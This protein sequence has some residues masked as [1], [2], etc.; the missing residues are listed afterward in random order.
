V[1]WLLDRLAAIA[2]QFRDPSVSLFSILAL[3]FTFLSTFLSHRALRKRFASDL[4]AFLL[5]FAFFFLLLFAVPLV[6]LLLAGVGT[7]L[8]PAALGLRIG[9]LKAG[10]L[11]CLVAVPLVIITLSNSARDPV[12]RAWYPFSKDATRSRGRFVLYEAAYILLY[13]FAWDFVFRGLVQFSLVHLLA[14]GLGGTIVAIMAQTLLSTLYHLGHPDGEIWGAFA[15][16]II[17][18]IIAAMTGSF[19]YGFLIHAVIGVANDLYITRYNR[20][21]A[22]RAGPA[23][24]GESPR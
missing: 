11:S 23:G 16:G 18:G 12:I 14:R 17:F 3:S 9:N 5:Y 6:F 2:A 24:P 13:Y 21:E 7:G 19:L 8:T 4:P 10:L 22:L 20:R 1:A 15:V